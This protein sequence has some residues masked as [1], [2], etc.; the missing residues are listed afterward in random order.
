MLLMTLVWLL[1]LVYP[2]VGLIQLRTAS[3]WGFLGIA[4]FAAVYTWAVWRGVRSPTARASSL[5]LLLLGAASV[6]APLL[7]GEG[8]IGG[9][10][11]AGIVASLTLS[12]RRAVA[13]VIAL[14]ALAAGMAVRVGAPWWSTVAVILTTGAACAGVLGARWLT[15]TNDALRAARAELARMATRDE[16]ARLSR[17]LHDSV[18]QQVF[19][20]ATEIG[21]ARALLG[22]D[23]AQAATHLAGA[24]AVIRR[25]Q[26]ELNALINE[27]PPGA[28]GEHGLAHALREYVDSWEGQSG[29]RAELH[30]EVERDTP[31]DVERELYRVAQ[32]ALA[33]VARHSGATRVAVHVE[34]RDGAVRLQVADDGRGLP[35]SQTPRG[36]GLRNIHDRMR[37]LGGSA[38]LES[39]PGGGARLTAV[40]PLG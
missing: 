28:L 6:A 27:T 3:P 18:K 26:T 16:R 34:W 38:A 10:L 7:Y 15:A 4:L 19:V 33:N 5:A 29:I 32:E 14:E 23:P 1:F 11:Y 35:P 40:C 20:A 37:A 13:M 21:A 17:E 12:T 39:P 36:S 22:R 30:I 31:P 24:D 8:W 9:F 2:I 25:A